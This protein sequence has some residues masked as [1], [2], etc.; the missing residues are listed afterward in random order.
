MGK[1]RLIAD[2]NTAEEAKKVEETVKT[3]Y[4][5]A[6]LDTLVNWIGVEDDLADSYEGLAS[7][8]QTPAAKTAYKRL[9]D[10]SRKNIEQLTGLQKSLESLDRARVQRLKLL[11]SLES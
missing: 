7:K 8:A 11:A 4:L 6:T 9:C 2:V 3:G 1:E 5:E 10:E